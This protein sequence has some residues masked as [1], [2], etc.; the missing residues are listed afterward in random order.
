MARV[1]SSRRIAANLITVVGLVILPAH[2]QE[3]RVQISGSV[4]GASGHHTIH[5][6]LWDKHGFLRTAAQESFLAPRTTVHYALAVPVGQ[7]AIAASEDR[8]EN[9]VVDSGRFGPKEPLGFWPAFHAPR[10]PRF[11]EV[12]IQIDHDVSDADITLP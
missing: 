12:A 5:I 1:I 6:L 7:W 9:G 10:H 3:R 4:R 8:N 2:A 11:A